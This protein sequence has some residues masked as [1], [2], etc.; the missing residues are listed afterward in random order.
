[1]MC[2]QKNL[3]KTLNVILCSEQKRYMIPYMCI[4][5]FN[6]TKLELNFLN[7]FLHDKK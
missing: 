5:M 4:E 1:M 6:V 7:L 2:W 3:K